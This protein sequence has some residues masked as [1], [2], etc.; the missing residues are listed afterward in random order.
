M[1]HHSA[2]APVSQAPPTQ[3]NF[4]DLF[5]GCALRMHSPL[6][7]RLPSLAIPDVGLADRVQL[8]TIE[9]LLVISPSN[10]IQHEPR[11]S[12][13]HSPAIAGLGIIIIS[14]RRSTKLAMP[15]GNSSVMGHAPFGC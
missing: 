12:L 2:Q 9:N 3:E 13:D 14:K 1:E 5:S 8:V 4:P 10:L 6:L 7:C 11:E 15:F